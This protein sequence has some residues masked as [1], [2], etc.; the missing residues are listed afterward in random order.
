MGTRRRSREIAVTVGTVG[1]MRHLRSLVV[2]VLSLAMS[3]ALA[4][5]SAG[6]QPATDGR[7]SAAPVSSTRVLAISVDGLSTEAIDRLGADGAPTLHRLL[8]E[9]AGTL[10]AR[11]EYEQTVTLPNHASMMTGRRINAAKDGHGVTWDDDR[12]GSTVQ[13]AAGHGVASIFT[14]VHAAD[15]STALYTTK[16]KFG[17]YERSWPRSIDTYRVRENQRRLV[18]LARADLTDGAP[19]FTFLHVSLPD[20]FGHRYGGMSEEYLAAVQRT[21]GQLGTVLRALA[22]TDVVVVLTADHG[23][24]TGRTDHSGRRNV[25]NYRIPFLAWGPGVD[26]GD[27]YALNP[28][29]ADP[30]TSRPSYAGRQPV[31]NGDVANLAASLLGLD[32]VPGSGLDADQSLVVGD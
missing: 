32:A 27:L 28:G 30:G 21:D 26:H 2:A 18:R 9:G 31:R 1:H 3:I 8:A 11:T 7:L 14:S 15:G 20:R 16:A 13:R 22:G 12:P 19:T 25:E 6:D 4:G 5:C 24:A 23:F 17:L 10:N 29:F